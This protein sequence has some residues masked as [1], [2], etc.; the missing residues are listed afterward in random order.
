MRKNYYLLPLLFLLSLFF[1]NSC[2][3]E[4]SIY[5]EKNIEREIN[6]FKNAE[7]KVSQI[8]G[9]SDVVKTLKEENEK[10][11]FI[12]KLLDQKGTPI[13]NKIIINKSIRHGI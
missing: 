6:F 13:W 5:E 3:Q 8:E 10:T 12:T 2:R 9:G 11:N 4:M 7:S 1:I